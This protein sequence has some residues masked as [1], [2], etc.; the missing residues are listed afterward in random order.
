MRVHDRVEQLLAGRKEY[1]DSDKKLLLAFWH[2]QGLHLTDLQRQIFMEKC[3]TAE[4]ITRARRAL[5]AKYPESKAIEEE[6]FNKYQQYKNDH[7]V[8]WL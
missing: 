2:T 6:R 3:T 8:S 1:R 5:R 4:S 7:A